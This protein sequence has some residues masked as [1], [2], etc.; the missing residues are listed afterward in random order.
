MNS[1][2]FSFHL[3]WTQLLTDKYSVFEP[4]IVALNAG[5]GELPM[6]SC[7]RLNWIEKTRDKQ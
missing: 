3:T 6:P 5:A 4:A 2:Y 1:D 7:W